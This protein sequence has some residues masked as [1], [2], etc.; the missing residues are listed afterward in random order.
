[1]KIKKRSKEIEKARKERLER[2]VKKT[3]EQERSNIVM[4]KK[5]I[6]LPVISISMFIIAI[7]SSVWFEEIKSFFVF[8]FIAL[9]FMGV[10]FNKY[11]DRKKTYE[12]AQ[13]D[14]TEYQ[15]R[16]IQKKK[17]EAQ[18]LRE[19]QEKYPNTWKPDIKCPICNSTN[20]EKI[21]TANRAVS[22]AM[23]GVASGKIGKQ[24]K[25]KKCKHMW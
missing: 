13:R 9:L 1:M 21:S 3:V 25:C 12:L 4:P 19:Q 11:S 10:E 23:V 8:G 7:L 24:Y 17:R 6:F 16:I 14:F 20:I 22:V 15:N 5:P 18:K 2:E